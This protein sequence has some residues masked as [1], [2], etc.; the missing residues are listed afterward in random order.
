MGLFR[1][2]LAPNPVIFNNLVL[3]VVNQLIDNVINLEAYTQGP[4]PYD[5]L[6]GPIEIAHE[7]CLDKSKL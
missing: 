4:V 6:L 7:A 3:A 5:N 1:Y 2:L